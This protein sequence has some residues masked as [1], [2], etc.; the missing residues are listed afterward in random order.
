MDIKFDVKRKYVVNGKEYASPEEMPAA[1]CEAYEKA[2]G[3]AQGMQHGNIS[4]ISSEK[5]VFNGQE[6]ENVNAMPLDVRQM[7]ETIMNAVK[8]EKGVTMKKSGFQIGLNVPG[9]KDKGILT[10]G[11]INSEPIEPQSGF[12][13]RILIIAAAILGFI[14]GLY[15]LSR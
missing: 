13:P 10:T 4:S 14:I 8:G 3:K 6:Y 2:V 15:I 12:S 11:G 1:I 9:I 5:I 7:Y